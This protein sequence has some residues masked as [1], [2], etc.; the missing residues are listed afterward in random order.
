[1]SDVLRYSGDYWRD[2]EVLCRSYRLGE[3]FQL[4]FDLHVMAN[5]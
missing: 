4:E 5:C 1:M 2:W 3:A